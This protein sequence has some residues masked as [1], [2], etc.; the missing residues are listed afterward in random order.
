MFVA[1]IGSRFLMSSGRVLGGT[2]QAARSFAFRFWSLR[3]DRGGLELPL[4]G[5]DYGDVS[6]FRVV[7]HFSVLSCFAT[8]TSCSGGVSQ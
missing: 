4:A 1:T 5:G 8:W 7:G 6:D 3:Q 2:A